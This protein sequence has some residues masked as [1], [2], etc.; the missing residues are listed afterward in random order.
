MRLYSRDHG[1]AGNPCLVI[2]HGLLGSSKNWQTAGRDLAQRFHVLAFDLRN[3]GRSPWGDVSGYDALAADVLETLAAEGLERPHLLG[4]SLGGKVAMRMACDAPE[5]IASLCVVDIAPRDYP[6]GSVEIRSMRALDLARF[7]ARRD[8]DRALAVSIPDLAARQFLLTNLE[9][10]ASGAFRWIPNL[11]ALEAAL[12]EIR[13]SPLG[14]GH[15]YAGPTLFIAG[16][17]SGFV[18]ESDREGIL[19]H[20]PG[21]SI[22][23]LPESGHHPHVEDRAGFVARV[24]LF[25]S[26]AA[27]ADSG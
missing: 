5:R 27:A 18:L 23:F 15:R 26:T 20:F 24:S 8:A 19:G 16:G 14:P 2:L 3:H 10:D 12:P 25:L 4:H 17:R 6:T 21:A 9:R 11:A 22:E 7:E 13:R 1:G